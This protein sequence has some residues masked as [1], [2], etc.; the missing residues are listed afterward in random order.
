MVRPGWWPGCAR[1]AAVLLELVGDQRIKDGAIAFVEAARGDEVLGQR[2]VPV[3]RPRL[4]R[5][6]ERGL[7]DHPIL[8]GEQPEEKFAVDA[9]TGHGSFPGI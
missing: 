7:G 8:N 3:E 9:R 6:D 5:L 2:P 4:D 1:P